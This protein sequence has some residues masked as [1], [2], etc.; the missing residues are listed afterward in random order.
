MANRRRDKNNIVALRNANGVWLSKR[1]D[2]SSFLTAHFS[3]ITTTTSPQLH[4]SSFYHI[5]DSITTEDN[6]SLMSM[7]TEDEIKQ[8]VRSLNSWNSP[9]PDGFP[10][11]F[12][13]SQWD[14][15]ST[16]IVAL[17]QNFFHQKSLPQYLNET[18]ICLIPNNNNPSTPNDYMPIGLCN[19]SYKILSKML[20][21]RM[22]PLMEKVISPTQDAYVPKRY[23][24]IAHELI[25]TMK[26]SRSKKG[27]I[28][29][30]LDMSKAF[31]RL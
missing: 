5:Q 2:L 3:A 30:K 17:V 22:Q 14:I 23:I 6:P 25:H 26:K 24:V 13:Q 31:D 9:G 20:V 10:D 18:T 16:D 29:L 4:D 28:A 11:G 12:Y 1:E 7:P 19:N 27:L 15:V 8:V 21:K